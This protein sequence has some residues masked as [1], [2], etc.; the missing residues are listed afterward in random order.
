ML[1]MPVDTN[2]F[3]PSLT[4]RSSPQMGNNRP[5]YGYPVY[6]HAIRFQR[7]DMLIRQFPEVIREIPEARLLI[8]GDGPQ[9]PKLEE[10][11]AERG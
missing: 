5:E 3:Y 1:L 10:I 4:H 11:I 2:L 9:R 8:V 7:L 6:W